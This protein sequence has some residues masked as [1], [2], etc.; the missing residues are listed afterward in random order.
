MMRSNLVQRAKKPVKDQV[1]AKLFVI[2]CSCKYWHDMPSEIY[3][4]L[5][6]PERL[7][8]ESRLVRTFSRKSSRRNAIFSS[9]PS[10]RGLPS[11]L[12][13]ANNSNKGAGAGPGT[14]IE[15]TSEQR[16]GNGN[17]SGASPPSVPVQCNWCGHGMTRAC[18]QGWTTLVQMRERHH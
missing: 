1:L 3:A 12:R 8:S 4:R 9:D 17:G 18:C 13:V 16:N 10:G 6:C 5:A 11:Q 14:G 7:P 2:C 15:G